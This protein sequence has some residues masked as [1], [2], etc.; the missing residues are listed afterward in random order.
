M[1]NASKASGKGALL[2]LSLTKKN[3]PLVIKRNACLHG[4]DL[5]KHAPIP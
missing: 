1:F 4:G 3:V 5:K 2:N